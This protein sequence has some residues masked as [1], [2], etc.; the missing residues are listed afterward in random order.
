MRYKPQGINKELERKADLILVLNELKT[1]A[2]K[3]LLLKDLRTY[4]KTLK[5][6]D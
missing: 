4:V 2:K 5:T 6:L 1:K 3:K